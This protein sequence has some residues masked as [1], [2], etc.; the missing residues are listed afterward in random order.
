MYDSINLESLVVDF[1]S[2]SSNYW[3]KEF[4]TFNAAYDGPKMKIVM[5]IPKGKKPPYQVV[6]YFPGA[7]GGDEIQTSK[8][9]EHE[10]TFDFIIKSGR[11]VVY[12]I[13]LGTYERKDKQK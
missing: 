13:Y 9:L 7:L 12:P 10:Q 2:V 5:Y 6:I 3:S 11:V 4:I 8:E 1:D